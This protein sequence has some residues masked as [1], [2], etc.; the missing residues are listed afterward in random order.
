MP[1]KASS[2][3]CACV[4]TRVFTSLG[5]ASVSRVDQLGS[6]QSCGERT[7]EGHASVERSKAEGI[8]QRAGHCHE[9]HAIAHREDQ[10]RSSRSYPKKR[11]TR[12][13]EKG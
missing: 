9:G 1:G 5:S 7:H 11:T 6:L 2:L 13:L 10:T 12:S 8:K 3:V 4:C